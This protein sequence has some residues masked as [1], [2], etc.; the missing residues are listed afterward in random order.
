MK[1]FHDDLTD[2][3]NTVSQCCCIQTRTVEKLV[4][5]KVMVSKSYS[6]WR[7][8]TRGYH[9]AVLRTAVFII[10]VSDLEEAT[11]SFTSHFQITANLNV[12][13]GIS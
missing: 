6:P 12:E 9:R 7:L 13:A 1:V 8:V 2:A 10:F 11:M 3:F 4:R 5:P